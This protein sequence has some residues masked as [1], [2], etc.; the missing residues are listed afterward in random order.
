LKV[1]TAKGLDVVT[2]PL[3]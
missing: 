1:Y 2:A 3:T